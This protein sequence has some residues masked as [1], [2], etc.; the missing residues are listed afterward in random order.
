[1]QDFPITFSLIIS[2]GFISW[3]AF[4]KTEL[5][6]KLI[7]W[8]AVIKEDGSWFRFISSGFIHANW[9][10]LLINLWVLWIFGRYVESA[11]GFLFGKAGPFLFLG[12]YISCLAVG[13]L[14]SFV[15]H[16]DNPAYKSLGASG[17]V[18]G[19]LFTFVLLEPLRNIYL[20]FIPIGIPAF[21]FGFIY[22]GYSWYMSK[23][24]L[25]NIGHDAHFFGALYGMAFLLILKPKVAIDFI[26]KIKLFLL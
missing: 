7:F 6:E 9:A 17:A 20:F 10:H 11:Y 18:S 4:R 12:M 16:E 19:V 23:K 8:P 21:I 26:N 1:M 3:S 5:Y 22:L 15:K 24:N 14:Y 2:I 25:D 13:E